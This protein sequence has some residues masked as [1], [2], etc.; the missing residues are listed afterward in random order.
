MRNDLIRIS[1]VQTAIS[2]GSSFAGSSLSQT[3]VVVQIR[4]A[5]GT[6]QRVRRVRCMFRRTRHV[7]GIAFGSVIALSLA[8]PVPAIASCGVDPTLN[9]GIPGTAIAFV[10]TVTSVGNRGR[11]ATVRV[12]EV[13][14][15]GDVAAVVEVVGTAADGPGVITS[16]DRSYEVGRQY[17]FVPVSG[18]GEHFDDNSCTAT[19]PYSASLA[20]FRPTTVSAPRA[21]S[22]RG[23][24]SSPVWAMLGGAATVAGVGGCAVFLLL[25]RRRRRPGGDT[26]A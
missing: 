11:I 20:A 22:S 16:V 1:A 19:Q 18:T 8:T 4:A 26:L 6:L 25:R 10:G 24:S 21:V 23:A 13:W 5:S 15:G 2:N 7:L 17:L 9:K 14:R 3:I 12:D